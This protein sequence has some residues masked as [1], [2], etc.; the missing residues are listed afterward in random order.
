MLMHT[1]TRPAAVPDFVR[2]VGGVRVLLGRTPRGTAPLEIGESGGFRVR[3]P[4]ASSPDEGDPPCEGVLINTGGG[5][6]GGDRVSTEATLTPG[7]RGVLTTQAAEKVYRSDGPDAEAT[8]ALTLGPE[9]RLDWLPQETILF[10]GARLRRRLRAEMAGDATLLLVES[11]VLGRA[12]TGETVES[13]SFRDRWRIRRDGRLVFAEDVRLEGPIAAALARPAVAKGG[14]AVA[15]CLLVAP[16]AE[17]RLEEARAA[18]EG[19]RSEC[20][21]S[22]YDGMLVARFLSPEPKSLR[23]D[24]IRYTECLRGPFPRSWQT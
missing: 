20:G 18:L 8:V 23:A 9:S 3:F 14:R 12:A 11:T 4:R 24:L 10:D 15:T 7:A 6:T 5:L 21:V 2:A 16:D 1:P 22:A 19:G 17:A 13:G